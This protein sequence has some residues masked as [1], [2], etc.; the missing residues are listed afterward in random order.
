MALREVGG[1]DVHTL[2]EGQKLCGTLLEIK[3][4]QG[5]D[6]NSDIVVVE[7]DEGKTVEAW[8]SAVLSDKLSNV[9]VGDWIQIEYIGKKKSEKTGREYKDW[10][11]LVDDEKRRSIATSTTESPSMDTPSKSEPSQSAEPSNN[12]ERM[13]W[14]K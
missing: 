14:E 6:N 10:K 11:L 3:G 9:S 1:G 4:N 5:R 8:S 7:T 13:P 12:G 2:E